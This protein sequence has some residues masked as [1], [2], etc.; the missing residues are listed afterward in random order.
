MKDYNTL[1]ADIRTEACQLADKLKRLEVFMMSEDFCRISQEQKSLL[2]QQ[3]D[4]MG[5]YKV[6]LVK[7]AYRINYER[8]QKNSCPCEPA[9]EKEDCIGCRYYSDSTGACTNKNK[10]DGKCWEASY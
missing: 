2:E 9:P 8:Q 10:K 6:T 4:L 7:R 3:Y 1:I 5:R